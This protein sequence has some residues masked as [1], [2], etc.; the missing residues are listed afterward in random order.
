MMA[1]WDEETIETRVHGKFFHLR[2]IVYGQFCEVHL[3]DFEYTYPDPV[4]CVLDPHDRQPHHLIWAIIDRTD[5][6]HVHSEM[7]IHCT[8]DELARFARKLEKK[9]GYN[10][11]RRIIDPN[12][13]RKPLIITGR[14]M[15]EELARSGCPGWM[16]ADDAKDEGHLKVKDYLRFDRNRPISEVNKPKIFFHRERVPKTIHSIRNYQYEEWIGKIAGERDPKEKPKDRETHGADVVRYLCMTNP[17]YEFLR[18]RN[19]YELEEP[20]Y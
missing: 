12:F 4:I 8:V 2:G 6:I 7:S 10:M 5:D 16:E 15:I 20:A 17:R 13:G 3:T 14:N 11:R 1:M 18:Y 9:E 19:D